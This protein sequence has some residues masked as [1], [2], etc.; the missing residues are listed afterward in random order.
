MEKIIYQNDVLDYFDD[1][2]YL[3]FNKE[4]FSYQENA[5]KYL[6]KLVHFVYHNIIDFPRRKTP[7]ELKYLGSHYIF[8]NSNKRTTWYIFFEK[9]GDDYLITGILNNHCEEA[10]GL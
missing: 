3:L 2:V 1:L 4:Y 8:Y 7:Q 10:N 9:D 6:E 5:E